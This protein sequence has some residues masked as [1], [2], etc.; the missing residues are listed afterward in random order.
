MASPCKDILI[1]PLAGGLDLKSQSGAVAFGN[2]RLILNMD[3]SKT[4]SW[5]RLNGWKRYGWDQE[6]VNN[7]DLHDQM[8]DGSGFYSAPYD[9]TTPEQRAAVHT[10]APQIA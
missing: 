7:L 8:V 9:Y 3:G 6:C 5:C 1:E 4:E 10:V 2:W